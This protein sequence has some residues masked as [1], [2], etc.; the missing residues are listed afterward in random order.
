M[1]KVRCRTCIKS[2]GQG[3][4]SEGNPSELQPAPE[5]HRRQPQRTAI[6]AIVSDELTD[7]ATQMA[8]LYP[9]MKQLVT[10]GSYDVVGADGKNEKHK[11][12][13]LNSSGVTTSP[14][15]W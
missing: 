13:L 12:N 7:A 8:A 5:I 15:R 3:I 10:S 11:V 9:F 4:G 1:P 6:A 14:M 2:N